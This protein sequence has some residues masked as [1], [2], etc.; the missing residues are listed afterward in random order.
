M[1]QK[2]HEL[3]KNKA[4]VSLYLNMLIIVQCNGKN[5]TDFIHKS[6]S[7]LQNYPY[8]YNNKIIYQS[9]R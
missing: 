4:M 2:S 6:L 3:C 9:D 7:Y 1:R 5:F 8:S